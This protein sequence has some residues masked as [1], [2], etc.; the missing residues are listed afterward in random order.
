[1][2]SEGQAKDLAAKIGKENGVKAIIIQGVSSLPT[3]W[4]LL[5]FRQ[6]I[7]SSKSLEHDLFV[8]GRW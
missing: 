7:E 3:S 4:N 6:P 8:L 5:N 2:S 1:M